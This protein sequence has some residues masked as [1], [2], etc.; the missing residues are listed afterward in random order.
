MTEPRV[1]GEMPFLDHLEELRWRIIWS[2]AAV[3]VAV[4]AAF[5]ALLN[6]DV[7]G[8][9]EQPIAPYLSGHKLVY[10]HPGDPFQ[11]ILEAAVILGLVAALPVLLYQ[12]WAFVS[13]ALYR[14]ERRVAVGVAAG[15]ILLFVAGVCLAYFVVLPLAI[16]WLLSFG[17]TSLQP[18]ITASEYFGFV[19][20]LVLAFGVAFELP[21]A[22]L[23][24]AALGIVTPQFL[25]RYRRHAIVAA[26][27]VGAFLTPGDLIWTTI[28]MT[29]PLYL[30]Y[31][32]S[33]VLS[34]GVYRAR[35]RRA[36]REAVEEAGH[37]AEPPDMPP[38][39]A[40]PTGGPS[41]I[42]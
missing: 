14:H 2:L 16:P 25:V 33:I 23:G 17:M 21:V 32:L 28:A 30:L 18:M 36:A 12:I 24:L 35:Q 19:F 11:I 42:A 20:S 10:T 13:P 31:E 4:G 8:W 39:A 38:P 7:I 22:I 3:V 6:F 1:D 37:R 26:V 34:Y 5:G 9:L 40:A 41:L 27:I 29:V 15:A